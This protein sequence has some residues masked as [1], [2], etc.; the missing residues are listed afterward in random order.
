MATP[1]IAQYFSSI[2]SLESSFV[3][4][5]SLSAHENEVLRIIYHR[6]PTSSLE[7]AEFLGHTCKTRK[8]KKILSS[9]IVYHVKKLVEKKY[10]VSKRFGNAL[11]VWPYVVEKKRGSR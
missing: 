10:V 8:Q 5:P 3:P 1:S 2:P 11:I 4:H 7:I 9:R 6:W